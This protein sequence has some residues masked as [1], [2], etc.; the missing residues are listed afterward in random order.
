[1]CALAYNGRRRL[2][3]LRLFFRSCTQAVCS[4]VFHCHRQPL[5][6]HRTA[7]KMKHVEFGKKQRCPCALFHL[8]QK[9]S[10]AAVI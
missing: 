9:R 1:M 2:V 8:K 3:A 6:G 4:F 7:Q 5:Y 10:I